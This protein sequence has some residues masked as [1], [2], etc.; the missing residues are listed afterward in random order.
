M[1]DIFYSAISGLGTF[2]AAKVTV[3]AVGFKSAGV[4]AGSLAA[5]MMSSTAVASGGAVASGSTVALLQS[6]GA[7]GFGI[8]SGGAVVAVGALGYGLAKYYL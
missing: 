5:S 2:A 1:E 8:V 7:A 6:I 4:A 3:C